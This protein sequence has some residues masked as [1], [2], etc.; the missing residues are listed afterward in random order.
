M[1]NDKSKFKKNR[2][3]TPLFLLILAVAIVSLAIYGY[4]RATPVYQTQ[5]DLP[6][7]EITPKFFDFGELEYGKIAEHSFLVKNSGKG[8][9][10]I[11]RVATSCACTKAKVAKEILEP[12]EQTLLFV[13]YD[14]GAMSGPHGKGKQERI[15]WIQSN[16]PKNPQ[17]EINITAYVK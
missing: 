9:L 2:T 12:G 15:V 7:I 4:F 5:R 6:R 14:T 3:S 13:R 1:Q 10:E 11:K 16:D 17:V 8:I